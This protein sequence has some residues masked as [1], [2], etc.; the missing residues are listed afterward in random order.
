MM[1][2][3]ATTYRTLSGTKEVLELPKKKNTQWIVYQDNQPAYFVDFY[4]LEHESNS[5]M[6]SLVLCTKRSITEVLELLN[7]RNNINLSI[8]KISR[9]GFSVKLKSEVK[10]IELQPIPE[11]WLSYSL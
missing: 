4:D 3:L 7:K 11:K 6:N 8:P 5:M 2:L 1:K 10:H 9:L